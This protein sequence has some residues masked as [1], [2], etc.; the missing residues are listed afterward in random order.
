MD[1]KV[2]IFSGLAATFAASAIY[3]YFKEKNKTLNQKMFDQIGKL[4]Y[5]IQ[6]HFYECTKENVKII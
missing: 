5:Y 4:N 3:L 6:N 1:N 2:K